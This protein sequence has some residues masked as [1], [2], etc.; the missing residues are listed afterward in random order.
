MIKEGLNKVAAARGMTLDQ[1]LAV[2]TLAELESLIS[3]ESAG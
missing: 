3:G 2:K 1:I